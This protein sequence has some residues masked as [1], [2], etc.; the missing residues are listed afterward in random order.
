M[1]VVWFFGAILFVVTSLGETFKA[2]TWERIC[3]RQSLSDK[4]SRISKLFVYTPRIAPIGGMII[5][6]EYTL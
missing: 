6:V 5:E 1:V 2:K 3:R 4:R